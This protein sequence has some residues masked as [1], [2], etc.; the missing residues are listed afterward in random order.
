MWIEKI[1]WRLYANVEYVHYKINNQIRG[2]RTPCFTLNIS[3]LRKDISKYS[4]STLHLQ[5]ELLLQIRHIILLILCLK[6]YEIQQYFLINECVEY[7]YYQC[8]WTIGRC[9]ERMLLDQIKWSFCRVHCFLSF[10]SI[11]VRDL[12]PIVTA[13][14]EVLWS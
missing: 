12:N 2:C 11:T 14:D 4:V 6:S 9:F 8:Y 10:I 3:F 7:N 13:G 1:Q 5:S